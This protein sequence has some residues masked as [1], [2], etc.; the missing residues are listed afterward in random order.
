MNV[1]VFDSATDIMHVTLGS[2]TGMTIS[3][4]V[5]T[6]ERAYNSAFLVSTIK[7]ILEQNNLKMPDI[8]ALGVNIGPGSFTGLRASVTVARVLAQ[9]LDIPVAGVPSMQIYSMLN[10]TNNPA[11]CLMDARRGMA[12]VGIYNNK[13]EPI[14][15]PCMM[16]YEEALAKAGEDDYFIICDSRMAK[17]IGGCTIFEQSDADFGEFLFKL[18]RD[19]LSTE[20]KFSWS[21]LKPLYI[22]T[23]PVTISKKGLL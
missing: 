14:L 2:E 9:Q 11:L 19:K 4:T 22:Q 13:S 12:F 10:T 6:T 16:P 17:K 8:S 23:P 7:G 20:N 1:L 5:K 18:T 3:R 21:E 15:E